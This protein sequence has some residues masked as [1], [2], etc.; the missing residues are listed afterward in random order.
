MKKSK[1]KWWEIILIVLFIFTVAVGTITVGRFTLQGVFKVLDKKR[2]INIGLYNIQVLQREVNKLTEKVQ[3]LEDNI[4]RTVANDF[5]LCYRVDDCEVDH[6]SAWLRPLPF[7]ISDFNYPDL[8]Y[9]E[10]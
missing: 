2:D 8:N 3:D 9:I 10:I 4:S 6:D 5:L 1:N 7:D